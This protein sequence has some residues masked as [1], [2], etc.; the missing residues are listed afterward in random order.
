MHKAA[1]SNLKRRDDL[2]AI[3]LQFDLDDAERL[4]TE[5]SIMSQAA[6][7]TTTRVRQLFEGVTVMLSDSVYPVQP[8]VTENSRDSVDES[9]MELLSLHL[10]RI[11]AKA[12]V[13][14]DQTLTKR[15]CRDR[16]KA[17]LGVSTLDQKDID[18]MNDFIAEESARIY[19]IANL[20]VGFLPASTPVPDNESQTLPETIGDVVRR[21]MAHTTFEDF[22]F[23]HYPREEVPVWLL[24]AQ[25]IEPALM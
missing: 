8:P 13:E 15:T 19:R 4:I 20:C 14:D 23:V 22:C 5:L 9:R 3:V 2:V 10:E 11:I 18:F 17:A 1:L 21:A 16:M 24:Q 25:D 12:A 6:E 7:H